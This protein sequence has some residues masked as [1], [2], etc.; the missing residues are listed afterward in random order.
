MDH[1]HSITAFI[2]QVAATTLQAQQHQELSLELL[3]DSLKLPRDFSRHPLF[4]VMFALESDANA[5][6]R[7]DWLSVVDLSDH[8]RTAK[9]DLT[10]TLVPDEQRLRARFNFAAA[11]FSPASIMR[12][13]GYYVAILQQMAQHSDW[14]SG[15][16]QLAAATPAGAT[17]AGISR[18]IRA[19]LAE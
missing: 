6:E 4:Q 13:A 19:H 1:Q 8:E 7:P 14:P 5:T 10:L 11:L 15:K 3:V 2:R 12:L 16:H 17:G 18:R 9:F